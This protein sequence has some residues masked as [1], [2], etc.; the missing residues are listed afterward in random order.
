MRTD[1]ELLR[2][3]LKCKA[4]RGRTNKVRV[5]LMTE[6]A[7][8]VRKILTDEEYREFIIYCI[9]GYEEIKEETLNKIVYNVL[10]NPNWTVALD[11]DRKSVTLHDFEQYIPKKQQNSKKEQVL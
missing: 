5:L 8:H 4:T 1:E 7:T 10:Q 11:V 9:F 6:I 3:L 2:L